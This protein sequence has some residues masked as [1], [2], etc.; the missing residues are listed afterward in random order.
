MW[1]RIGDRLSNIIKILRGFGD[2]H[3]KGM[4]G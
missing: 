4:R 3:F 1:R 2:R